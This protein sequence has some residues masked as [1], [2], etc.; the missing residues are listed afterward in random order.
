MPVRSLSSEQEDP[1][2]I[3]NRDSQVL[4]TLKMNLR[5]FPKAIKLREDLA[6]EYMRKGK[7]ALEIEVRKD[8]IALAGGHHGVEALEAA[9]KRQ[10]NLELAIMGWKELIETLPEQRHDLDH[11]LQRVFLAKGVGNAEIQYWKHRL[12]DSIG[13]EFEAVA[14]KLTNSLQI[15]GGNRAVVEMWQQLA[16]TYPDRTDVQRRLTKLIE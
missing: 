13:G 6:G 4:R 8:V 7:V 11:S 9:Y 1:Y 15:V 3:H 14:D 12:M 2:E 10:G 5:E 16:Q